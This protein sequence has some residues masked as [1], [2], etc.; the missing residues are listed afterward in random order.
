MIVNFSTDSPMANQEN[1]LAKLLCI[2]CFVCGFTI[3]YDM[4]MGV[5]ELDNGELVPFI[6]D[7]KI[8]A[9][10]V[11]YTDMDGNNDGIFKLTEHQFGFITFLLTVGDYELLN[12]KIF[13]EFNKN[14][15]FQIS[16]ESKEFKSSGE[17]F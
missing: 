8:I 2:P 14:K 1:K 13:D 4:N 5:D 17:V 10:T 11:S 9:A 6:N 12:K 15:G 16:K 7:F 3:V